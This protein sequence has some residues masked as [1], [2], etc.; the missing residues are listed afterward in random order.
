[1]SALNWKMRRQW[2]SQIR[3]D[4][5]N[6]DI[7]ITHT[8]KESSWTWWLDTFDRTTHCSVEHFAIPPAISLTEAKRR[9]A[10]DADALLSRLIAARGGA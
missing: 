5:I 2:V 7:T 10:Q 9:S 4:G 3:R 6:V 8:A 1:M